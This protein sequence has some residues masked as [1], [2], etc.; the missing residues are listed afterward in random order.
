MANTRTLAPK[1]IM[2]HKR[3]KHFR[4]K[5]AYAKQFD[6]AGL[7]RIAQQLRECEETEVLACCTHCGAS[8]YIT[9]YCRLRVCPLCSYRVSIAR[10]EYLL[11][12]TRD[13]AHP[14]MLTLTMPLWT[15]IPQDGI[16]YL[17]SCFN[18]LRRKKIMRNVAGGA[19]TIEVKIKPNGYH[20]HM[21]ALIDA[22]YLPHQ[23]LFTAWREI[24][25]TKA[26]QVDIRAASSD[27]A[28]QY[29]C[30]YTSKGA[31]F[32]AQQGT[33]VKWYLATKGQ[34]LFSTFG[35]WY[36]AKIEE[37]LNEEGEEPPKPTCPIC[38][39]QNTTF[40]ARDGPFIYGHEEWNTLARTFTAGQLTTRVL[41]E[42]EFALQHPETVK[43]EID[44]CTDKN[45]DSST[46][47]RTTA[48]VSQTGSSA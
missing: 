45:E 46:S 25:G 15:E 30:K 13:M 24:I 38:K 2:A 17:R 9:N 36:N 42:V 18:K 12:I 47:T 7:Y 44:E 14:K 34:R 32:D 22:P 1:C 28:K 26:P 39:K 3:R 48:H 20:I 19:Y 11:A 29:V 31:D 10:K 8:W 37:L 5:Q 35:K 27:K 33:I 6:E 23:Q 41:I 16:K 43:E 21:H 4:R 40:L